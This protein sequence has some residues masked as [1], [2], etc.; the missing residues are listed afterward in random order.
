MIKTP[1]C[2]EFLTDLILQRTRPF[3]AMGGK[4]A[5]ADWTRTGNRAGLIHALTCSPADYIAYAVDEIAGDVADYLAVIGGRDTGRIV[6]IGCGNGIAETLLCKALPCQSILLVD[7]ERG[8]SGHGF[9]QKAA[10]Y[11]SLRRSVDLMRDNGI[12]CDIAT[13]NPESQ[14]EPVFPFGVLLS[15]YAMGFHFPVAAYDGFIERNRMPGALVIHDSRA[16]R[17]IMEVP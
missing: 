14:P 13:W 1:E 10:G 12:T 16:G 6:S 11:G 2:S 15:M 5:L 7:I 8:G 9:A 4:A 3:I 17:V